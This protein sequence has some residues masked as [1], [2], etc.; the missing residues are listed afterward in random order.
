MEKKNHMSLKKQKVN[1]IY[2]TYK[3]DVPRYYV[4]VKILLFT[5]DK[6]LRKKKITKIVFFGDLRNNTLNELFYTKIFEYFL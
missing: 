1:S 6:I 2:N 3:L 5:L 4:G